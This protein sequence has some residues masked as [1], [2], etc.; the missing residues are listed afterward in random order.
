M[1]IPEEKW[2]DREFMSELV[3]ITY[4]ALPAIKPK[5]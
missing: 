3:T 4:N 2:E 5:N 1:L